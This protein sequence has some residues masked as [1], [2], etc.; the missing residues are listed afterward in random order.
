MVRKRRIM[1]MIQAK[2]R[3]DMYVFRYTGSLTTPDC[4]ENVI[5]TNYKVKKIRNILIIPPKI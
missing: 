3:Y 2:P 1:I 5:W 4:D